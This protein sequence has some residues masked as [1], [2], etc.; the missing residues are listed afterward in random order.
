MPYDIHPISD[1]Q[2]ADALA[3]RDLTDPAAGDHCMQRL[4]AAAT[5]VDSRRV[6]RTHTSAA[7]PGALRELSAAPPDDVL[8]SVPGL[9][10]RRDSIDRL[11]VGEPHQLDLWRVTRTPMTKADLADMVAAVVPA[12]VPGVR[13]R[14]LPA[15]HP[16]TVG[17]LQ[18]DV[19]VDGEWVELLE[20]GLAHPH[21]LAAAGLPSH[22][23]LAMGIGRVGGGR[24]R[25]LAHSRRPPARRRPGA[26]GHRRGPGEPARLRAP[27]APDPVAIKGRGQ[28]SPRPHLRRHPR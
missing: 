25:A 15:A 4:V 22:S 23:G 21:V 18:V 17:G 1:A 28:P 5:Y 11:H 10:W 3:L 13:Q 14:M 12:L 8:V 7:I 27:A 6:L 19:H 24:K 16:Y 2:L 9:V 26:D 20:C